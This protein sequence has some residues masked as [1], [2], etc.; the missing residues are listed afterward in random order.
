M[1]AFKEYKINSLEQLHK[2]LSKNLHS[3]VSE[4]VI[5]L[6]PVPYEMNLLIHSRQQQKIL[7]TEELLWH[8]LFFIF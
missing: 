2:L 8:L 1:I 5:Q 6:L 7:L 4:F 3:S